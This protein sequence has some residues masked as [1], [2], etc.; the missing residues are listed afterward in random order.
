MHDAPS[1]E[2]LALFCLFA[3]RS[4]RFGW[5][6][7]AAVVRKKIK[8]QYQMHLRRPPNRSQL[9]ATEGGE[10]TAT[11][12]SG[13][14]KPASKSGPKKLAP[15]EASKSGPKKPASQDRRGDDY[16][17]PLKLVQDEAKKKEKARQN[18]GERQPAAPAE[19]GKTPTTPRPVHRSRS[20]IPRKRH[21]QA[22]DSSLDSSLW[23][24]LEPETPPESPKSPESPALV[25]RTPSG[26]RPRPLPSYPPPGREYPLLLHLTKTWPPGERGF[27][28][29]FTHDISKYLLEYLSDP[30]KEK[31]QNGE[32]LAAWHF[33]SRRILKTTIDAVKDLAD[34]INYDLIHEV[35]LPFAFTSFDPELDYTVPKGSNVNQIPT[36]YSGAASSA[37]ETLNNGVWGNR[38]LDVKMSKRDYEDYGKALKQLRG[39]L[40][41]HQ[42]EVRTL[43]LEP[44]TWH[45]L[46]QIDPPLSAVELGSETNQFQVGSAR[47]GHIFS[48]NYRAIGCSPNFKRPISTFIVEDEADPNAF[49]YRSVK[50]SSLAEFFLAAINHCEFQQI[51]DTWQE[52]RHK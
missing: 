28:L 43:T 30:G 27:D 4:R 24:L 50:A 5:M 39:L 2:N 35:P 46:E 26:S 32:P 51:Y 41:F 12:K 42:G 23:E 44:E 13:P 29:D 3:A 15:P 37:S 18:R 11:S 21:K 45:R 14:P 38:R 40:N 17:W 9:A 1:Q 52:K 47:S 22:A 25:P 19:S 10:T 33:M 31:N 48:P 34:V 8:P 49:C 20:P 36:R 16:L 6:D 7:L